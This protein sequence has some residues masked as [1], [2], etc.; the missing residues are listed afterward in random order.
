MYVYMCVCE[1]VCV[2]ICIYRCIDIQF[3]YMYVYVCRYI[4]IYIITNY[5]CCV[6]RML[7]LLY[8]KVLGN[9]VF[10]ILPCSDIKTFLL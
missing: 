6:C 7:C 8:I 9:L 4:H 2:C 3:I 10:I 1:S 5:V